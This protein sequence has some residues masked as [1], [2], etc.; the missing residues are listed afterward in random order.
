MSLAGGNVLTVRG[1]GFPTDDP[2][3]TTVNFVI[4]D[5]RFGSDTMLTVPCSVLS[6]ATNGRSLQCV[7][8][9]PDYEHTP[10]FNILLYGVSD[11]ASNPTGRRLLAAETSADMN[12]EDRGERGGIRSLVSAAGERVMTEDIPTV[13]PTCQPTLQPSMQVRIL[14]I[15]HSFLFFHTN[16][17]FLLP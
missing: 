17:N 8:S 14:T 4:Y 3:S 10:Y 12:M 6:V 16:I 11:T 1:K 5:H 13:Q 7:L 9:R 2:S 15:R